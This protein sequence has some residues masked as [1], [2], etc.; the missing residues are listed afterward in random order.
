MRPLQRVGEANRRVFCDSIGDGDAIASARFGKSSQM[1]WPASLSL[2]RSCTCSIDFPQIDFQSRVSV[3]DGDS[4]RRG[5]QRIRLFGIDAP[6]L[7]QEC[8]DAKGRPYACGQAAKRALQE[9]IGGAEISCDVV[10]RDKYRRDVAR[11][12]K[13]DLEINREMVRLGWALAYE[14]HSVDYLVAE[15]TAR[16]ARRGLWQGH[17]QTPEDFRAEQRDT[18]NRGDMAEPAMA[19]SGLTHMGAFEQPTGLLT[20]WCVGVSFFITSEKVQ[21]CLSHLLTGRSC[22]MGS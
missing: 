22:P 1:V 14:R 6:E 19:G 7:A 21:R 11:C 9:L 15:A 4:F 8:L 3:T 13:N 17:F 5:K 18:V 2:L 16:N 10:E 20:P 12:R